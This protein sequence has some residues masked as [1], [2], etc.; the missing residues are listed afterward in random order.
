MA[1]DR[2]QAFTIHLFTSQIGLE[3][4]GSMGL[5]VASVGLTFLGTVLLARALGPADYGAYVYVF[6]LV[7]FLSVPSKFGL[8]TMVVRET[9]RGMAQ[10]DYSRVQGVWRW[11]GRMTGTISIVLVTLTGIFILFFKEPFTGNRLETF[12]WGLA[13]VPLIALGDLRGAAL[14]GLQRVFVGQL[15]EFLI[16]PGIFAFLLAGSLWLGTK[17]L[18]APT[19]IGLYVVASAIA[20]GTGVGLLRRATPTEISR[21]SPHYENRSWLISALPLAFVGG[22]QLVNQQASIL[23]QGFYLSDAEIGIFRVAAQVS[24]LA[25]FG[26]L[27]INLVIAPRFAILYT[28]N[29]ISKLQ[30]LVS[31]SSQVIL[32][33][34]LVVTMGFVLLGKTFLRLVFGVPY[35]AAYVPLVILLG[36]QLVNSGVGSVGVLLNMTYN[37]RETA[38]ALTVSAILNIAFNLLLIPSFG[39]V[40]SAVATVISLTSW[41]ILLWM[42]VRKHL[43]INSFAFGKYYQ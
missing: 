12:L 41:N 42:A 7:S 10:K 4:L 20:F 32:A 39:I 29:N 13:L 8:P 9:A 26:L 2:L 28:Q 1:R 15:P 22:M 17:S 34:S 36:G 33:F 43:G 24:Q 35:V 31:R 37:E 27:V 40:G 3:T 5:K 38:K 16:R 21:S 25:S 19:A 14:R 18:S 23:L 30:R 6:A 11:S